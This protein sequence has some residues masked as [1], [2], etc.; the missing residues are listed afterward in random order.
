MNARAEL[1]EYTISKRARGVWKKFTQW[2]GGDVIA[3]HFG[4]IPPQ[5]WCEVIDS[6]R[7][8]PQMEAILAEIRA[9]HVTFPPRFPEFEAIVAQ[10]AKAL[11]RSGPL[12]QERIAAYVLSKYG[13][14][15]T[16]TQ[17]RRPWTYIGRSFDAP[18]ASGKMVAGHGIEISGV[19]VPADGDAPGYRVM[20]DDV[21]RDAA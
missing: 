13:S 20:I 19:I 5:E 11:Q 6:I 3:K 7:T 1:P 10:H 2:Y 18:T 14:R 21:E 17:I 12:A 8:R 9:K 4:E 15:L 16:P